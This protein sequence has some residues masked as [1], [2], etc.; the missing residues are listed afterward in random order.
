M[1][2]KITLRY[3]LPMSDRLQA[4]RLVYWYLFKLN[5]L[6]P[7]LVI[8]FLCGVVL[9][10]IPEPLTYFGIFAMAFPVFHLCYILVLIPLLA[11]HQI[12]KRGLTDSETLWEFSDDRVLVK[13]K[14]SE[15]SVNWDAFKEARETKK[16]YLLR[17]AAYLY[18]PKTAFESK[19][20]ESS[21]RNIINNHIKKV[22]FK[23][24]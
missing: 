8:C 23:A 17:I 10:V 20:Q 24:V 7:G 11:R 12:Q 13:D 2:E 4:M 3:T 9:I 1:S 22:K 15:S 19:E 18:I 6:W 14:L 21:F 16:F 5:I